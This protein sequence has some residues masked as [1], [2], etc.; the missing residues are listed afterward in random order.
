MVAIGIEIARCVIGDKR[1]RLT[2][3]GNCAH[4]F[5]GV[6]TVTDFSVASVVPT[7]LVGDIE[8]QALKIISLLSCVGLNA[9]FCLMT[10]GVDLGA[11][12]I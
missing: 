4:I 9:S 1:S 11:G 8:E 10:Y 7:R 5:L 6:V 2:T 3:S 12:W